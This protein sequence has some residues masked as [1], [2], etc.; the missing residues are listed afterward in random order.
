MKLSGKKVLITRP[1]GQAEAFAAALQ[2]AGALPMLFPAIAIAP[3]EDTGEL[4]Q[5]LRNLAE[6]DWLVLTSV[7]GVRMVWRRLQDLGL[8]GLPPSLLVAAIGPKTAEALRRRG[9]EPAF[10][11]G[12]FIAEAIAPGLEPLQ[13]RRVLLLRAEI[14]RPALA[15]AIR[16]AG[17]EA[18][19]IPVYRTLAVQPEAG[20]L[21]ALLEGVDVVTF[22]SS[23]TV[24]NFAAALRQVGIDPARLPGAPVMACIGPI[25]A[26]A[27]REEGL[28]VDVVAEE[29]TTQGLL[30]ALQDYP[31]GQT[32][33]PGRLDDQDPGVGAS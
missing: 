10:V 32:L 2:A 8:P 30:H 7:N 15:Q 25:T 11:P 33:A 4:D 18:V 13:G 21:Q 24:H 22:T 23:S 28:P 16:Q 6:Y 19:E 5:A 1:R 31:A 29:Y 17:G 3:M 9:V 20:A 12:E 27:A 26:Q 14:A